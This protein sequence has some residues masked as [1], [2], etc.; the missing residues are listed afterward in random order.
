M[1][2]AANF[3]TREIAEEDKKRKANK[4]NSRTRVRVENVFGYCELNLHGMFSRFIGFAR[5]AA[6]NTLTNLVYNVCRY[7]QIVR[8]GMN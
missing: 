8:L 2:A 6:R 7:E 1:V 3:G 4:K 5:N